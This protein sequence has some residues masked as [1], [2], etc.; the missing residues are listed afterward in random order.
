MMKVFILGGTGFIG[1]HAVKEL[2]NRGHQVTIAALPPLPA[3]GLFPPEVKIT[4]ADF[5]TLTDD[6]A[7]QLLSG[8]DAMVHAA[9]ADDRVIPKAPAYPFF[10]KANVAASE[11]LFTLAKR[12]G[13]KKAVMLGSYFAYFNR[14]WADLKLA[15]KH[16]YIRSRMEQEE[17]SLAVCGEQIR[18][19]ILEL[20]YIFGSMPGREPLWKPLIQYITSSF[21]LFYTRGG[22]VC[23]SVKQVAQAIAGA[24]ENEQAS[25]Q[26]VVGEA[27]LTWVELM[28][29]LSRMAGKPKKVITL[30]NWLV[31][32]GMQF[33]YW[34]HKAQGKESGLD[35]RHLLELQGALTFVDTE[36]A[37]QV[38]GFEM[39]LLEEALQETVVASLK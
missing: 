4:L 8:H 11:W 26:Y 24:L 1:Y 36:P 9:G 37:R 5:N 20:P 34:Q 22:T 17:R 35:P 7:L 27:N 29:K 10:Y 21:P 25:G 2:I 15:E 39:A 3:D 28:G 13:V 6:E 18:L 19:T 23:V 31:R 38:L 30:P 14:E 32:I 12:A 16:P 33:L